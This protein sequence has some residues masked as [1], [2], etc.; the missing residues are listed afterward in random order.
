MTD[1]WT[2]FAKG[3]VECPL[4]DQRLP[5]PVKARIADDELQTEADTAEVWSHIWAH[6]AQ[7]K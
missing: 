3:H 2:P 7:G 1:D 4:C 5:V 6:E